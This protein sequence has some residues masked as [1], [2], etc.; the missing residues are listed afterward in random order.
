MRAG[1]VLATMRSLPVC[2]LDELA[3]DGVLILAPHQDDECLGCGGLIALLCAAGRP[4]AVLFVTDGAMSHP[5]SVLFPPER[6]QGVREREALEATAI[7]GLAAERVQFLGYPDGAAPSEGPAFDEAVEAIRRVA[8]TFGCSAIAAP[9]RHDPHCDHQAV[10]AMAV[11]TG[12]R[13]LSYP[14]WGWLLSRDAELGLEHA[15]SGHR[16]AIGNVLDRKCRALAAHVSQLGGLVT[17]APDG[18]CVPRALHDA[19]MTPFELF[20]E[21]VR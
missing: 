9:W 7:L 3:R 5:G 15:P 1:D 2:S 16:L 18:F 8:S 10:Q 17:D 21:D 6:L 4:P 12:L 20:L 13:V 19:C 11:A 14:V